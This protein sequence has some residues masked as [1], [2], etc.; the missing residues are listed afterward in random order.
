MSKIMDFR[1]DTVTKATPEML[2]AMVR[3]EVGDDL[4]GDDPTVQ[5]L[6][7]LGAAMFGKEA[8]LFVISGTMA[9]QVAIMTMM[10]PGDEVLVGDKSHIYNLEAGGLAAI[11]G[12]QSRVLTSTAGRF[13]PDDLRASIR[14]RG[15]QSP[16]TRVLCLENTFDLN[17]GIPLSPQYQA[18]M[19]DIAHEHGLRVYLDGARI[20]NAVTAFGVA[21]KEFGLHVDALQFCLSK[22]LAAPVGSLLLGT[23]K[24]IE[25]ARWIRQ[26][27][28]G[29]MRQAGHMAAAGI[30]AL[31]TMVERLADDHDNAQRLATGLA[32][33]DASLVDVA[34][35]QTNIVQVEFAAYGLQAQGVARDLEQ[36]GIR[37]KPISATACRMITHWGL[38]SQDVDTAV[39]A[40]AGFLRR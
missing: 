11:S 24:F 8:G 34:Q 39:A 13:D 40:I 6:E 27:F 28:G 1:S 17:R 31:E 29:G 2:E 12:V 25:R 7:A 15:V 35:T 18:A 3:A 26:R 33:I 37:V 36:Q 9:N 30:V 5:K 14:Q 19:A 10:Q 20:F 38:T 21:P 16:I 22:G 4:L 32:D 23:S